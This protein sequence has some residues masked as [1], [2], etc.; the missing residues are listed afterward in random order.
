MKKYLFIP[1]LILSGMMAAAAPKTV[2]SP[3]GKL[4]VTVSDDARY[5]IALEGKTILLPS[6]LGFN[7]NRGDFTKATVTEAETSAIHDSYTL[8]R[9]KKGR[10]TY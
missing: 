3:D 1:C 7:S 5:S 9:I 8:D 2:S 4:T 6:A 10:I